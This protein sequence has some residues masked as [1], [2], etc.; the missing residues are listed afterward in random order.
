MPG[1][2][3]PG[4][5]NTSLQRR[6]ATTR[7]RFR[8]PAF[9][10]PR[11]I[12]SALLAALLTPLVCAPVW[13]GLMSYDSLFAYKQAIYGV[14]TAVWP[15][16]HNYFFAVSRALGLGAGGVFAAQTFTL[17]FGA[18]L[19]LSMLVGGPGRFLAAFAAF[20]GLFYYFP[21]MHGTMLV[22]WKDVPVVSFGLL[23][24][25]LWMLAVRASSWAAL[26][27]AVL[28]VSVAVSLRHN[29]LPL[30]LPF[31]LLLVY[32]PPGGV[33]ARRAR[34][35]A[36]AAVLVG[37]F[38]AYATTV[39]RLPDF[40]RMPSAAG[41][42]AGVQQ[43]DLIGVSA[44]ADENLLPPSFAAEGALTAGELRALYDPRHFNLP[45]DLPPGT[46]RLKPPP[47]DRSAE[48]VAAWKRAL[49]SHTRCYLTHRTAVFVEQMGLNRR[50]VFYPTHGGIDPNP[51]G[52]NLADAAAASAMIRHVER[53]ADQW[54]RRPY[55]LYLLAGLVVAA[56]CLARLAVRWLLLALAL[57][58]AGYVAS[59]FFLMPAADARYIFPSSAFCALAVVLGL[60]GLASRRDGVETQPPSGASA[61]PSEEAP[62]A[63]VGVRDAG[64]AA[65]GPRGAAARLLPWAGAAVAL[66]ALLFILGRALYGSGGALEPAGRDAAPQPPAPRQATVT[67]DPLPP[68]PAWAS[69]V[70]GKPVRELFPKTADCVGNAD[71]V[72]MRFEGEPP[73]AQVIGWGWESEAALPVRRVVLADAAG[74]VVGVGEGGSERPDVPG[75]QPQVTTTKTGWLALVGL[76][77]GTVEAYGV[78]S[79]PRTVCRL[80]A[81][82][83]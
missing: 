29:G 65:G 12:A 63:E 33:G 71:T 4:P 18:G 22:L 75:R 40:R 68:Y 49:V 15:P 69:E 45:A 39:W 51:Y 13:P 16:M 47:G 14:E 1:R 79:R 2:L 55:I 6:R 19:V 43:W 83:W 82:T 28:S 70:M 21:T 76:R 7:P 60:A 35:F 36:A 48:I 17:F 52:L 58:A 31:L 66:G 32:H 9:S 77:S 27:L 62:A 80:G 3:G 24:V 5:E 37:L 54:W 72:V 57:G 26:L 64:A 50:G 42:F 38:V 10:R 20:A 11:L 8:V 25:A 46:K 34:L 81:V 56:A 44:C 61:A 23:G 30:F 53:G 78:T 73:G 67:R 41:G 74:R 59:V